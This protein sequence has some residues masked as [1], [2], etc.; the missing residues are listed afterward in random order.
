MDQSLRQTR[1]DRGPSESQCCALVRH[2]VSY[3]V[4]TTGVSRLGWAAKRNGEANQSRD[5]RSCS[6][7]PKASYASSAG[8]SYLPSQTVFL[9]AICFMIPRYST[10]YQWL[11]VS[12]RPL[13][14]SESGNLARNPACCRFFDRPRMPD[15]LDPDFGQL[16]PRGHQR[17][18]LQYVY[19]TG[20]E[21]SILA[22]LWAQ[23]SA[24]LWHHSFILIFMTPLWNRACR[25]AD[26]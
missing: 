22:C 21:R 3:G 18:E 23:S 26:A 8:I 9:H 6:V 24:Y 12:I 11:C 17:K 7:S 20:P 1:R 2:H 19:I 5:R 25:P 10:P 13:S 14:L 4:P 15:N 16:I